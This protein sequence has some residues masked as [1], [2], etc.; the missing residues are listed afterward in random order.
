MTDDGQPLAGIP[1]DR[2]GGATVDPTANVLQLVDAAVRRQDDLRIAEGRRM[3]DLRHAEAR[4]MDD[5]RIAEAKRMDEQLSMRDKLAEAESKRIDAIRAVDVNAVAVAS[6]RAA[7]QASVL[8][9]QV[10]ASAETQRAL[11]AQTASTIAQQF[12]QTTS[13]LTERLA[14]LEKAQYENQGRGLVANPAIDAR[15]DSIS[16]SFEVISKEVAS[17]RETR[18]GIEGRG[19]GIGQ[20]VAWIIAAIGIMLAA[21]TY[22]SRVTP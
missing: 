20:I 5:L 6:E 3:D 9:N 8:A 15:F 2:F 22:L 1:V 4:R 13:Q 18:S 12:A 10:A 19:A 14:S 21:L 16:R 11:V 17:L 7:A